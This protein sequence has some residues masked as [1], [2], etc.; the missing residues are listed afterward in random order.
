LKLYKISM[1]ITSV[2]ALIFC[3]KEN[4]HYLSNG[5]LVAFWNDLW[6]T[7]AAA[8]ITY[9]ILFLGIAVFTWMIHDARKRKV[10]GVW[11]Y[12]VL[13]M[14][15]AISVMVPLYMIAREKTQSN[16]DT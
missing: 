1:L 2:L 11:I 5:G 12:M 8:S 15:V 14:V 10:K 16:Q 3:W 4:L 13:S 9:D 6:V 7:H